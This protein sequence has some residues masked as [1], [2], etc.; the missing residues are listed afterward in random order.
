MNPHV[1]H[2]RWSQATE[3]RI[4]ESGRRPTLMFNGYEEQ[5]GHLYAGMDLRDE[6]LTARH[7]RSDIRFAKLLVL[8]N[9]AVPLALLVWDACASPARRQPAEF[10]HPHHRHDDADFPDAD[11]GGDAAAQNHRL[12]LAD[13]FRA[14][15]SGFTPFFTA[16]CISLCFF[17]LDQAFS[18]SST[19][20]EM[21]QTQIP[22][23]GHHGAAGHG[24]AGHHFD[25]RDDQTPRR[26]TLA[27]VAPAGVC[28]RH[29]GVIHYYMQVKA[30][31]RQP[32][33]FAAVL[34]VL[35]GYRLLDYW[36]RPKPAGGA[37]AKARGE[38]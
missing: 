16:A 2:P 11:D 5:V 32:L 7:E 30:D 23:R 38:A 21:R 20:T 8:V 9:G 37:T 13:S 24:A 18:V 25:Q 27:G 10:R 12:E 35:L 36:R 22:D 33:V 26:Q 28:G 15:R 4:G 6:F 29:C 31:V 19:L 3:Q 1:D 17:S 14:G 34:V